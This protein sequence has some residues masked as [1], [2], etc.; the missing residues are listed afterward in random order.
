MNKKIVKTVLTILCFLQ[1]SAPCKGDGVK[2]NLTFTANGVSFKMVFVQGGTFQMGATSE[3]GDE[4]NK[5]EYPIHEV[6]LSDYY[7]GEMEVT[8]ELWETVM[9]NNISRFRGLYHPVDNVSWDECQKFI[10]KLNVMTG[11]QFRLPTEAE[12]EFAARGGAASKGYKYSG[13][14]DIDEVAWYDKISGKRTHE[15]GKKAPNELGFYDLSGNVWEWCQDGY[16]R[17]K[18]SPLTNPTGPDNDSYRIIRGGCWNT[19]SK[20]CRVSQRGYCNPLDFF[21][22]YGLRL[23]LDCGNYEQTEQRTVSAAKSSHFYVDLGLPS[24]TLWATCNIGANSPEEYGDYFA[25]GETKG[26]NSGKTDFSWSTY[27]WCNGSSTSLTKYN[28]NS[29]NGIVDNKTELDLEDD[30]AYVN[31]G[32]DWRM[33]SVEQFRELIDGFNTNSEWTSLNGVEGYKITSRRNGNSIFLPAEGFRYDSSLLGTGS[34]GAYSSRTFKS[35]DSEYVPGLFLDSS[36][37]NMTNACSRDAGHSV[38]PVRNKGFANQVQVDKGVISKAKSTHTYADL[39]LPSG[40]LWAT[41]NVGANSPEEYGDYF[42]WGETK[43][44]NSGKTEFSLDTYKWFK[45]DGETKY[46]GGNKT[47]LDLEDDVAYVNWGPEWRMPSKEQFRELID[48]DN[49]YSDWTTQNG[50]K[51]Y[52]ITSRRNGNSIFLPAAG[53]RIDSAFKETGS[54]GEYWFRTFGLD[55]DGWYYN[56]GYLYL[57]SL[58]IGFSSNNFLDDRSYGHSIRP[59]RLPE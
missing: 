58:S 39:G 15:V 27:K 54:R 13:S 8:Q 17:Y 52:K 10:K 36:I 57:Y 33:P 19:K 25:W 46:D 26:Y 42:A 50:V 51:G 18:D 35:D 49:T 22:Y 55:E 20:D 38:R 45:E 53:Y 1:I 34:S 23:A 30:A 44:Y 41:C 16:G 2:K 31:W 14:N 47:E 12:W 5:N 48:D 43:G 6:S 3:Q 21:P 37:C 7:M 4:A 29:D 32:P 28:Y 9:E 56:S 59:V 40:T 11:I 24:G